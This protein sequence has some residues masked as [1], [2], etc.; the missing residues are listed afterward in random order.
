MIVLR[1]PKGWRGPEEVDG[2]PAEGSWRSHQVPF[3]EV[4]TNPGHLALLKES[5]RSYGPEEL[6]DEAAPWFPGVTE[7][8]PRGTARERQP[9]ANGRL[10]TRVLELPD[11]RDYA[12]EVQAPGRPAAKRRE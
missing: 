4:R 1:T 7:L 2:L 3:G 9:H 12:V 8:A 10:L 11:F 6:F 5:L